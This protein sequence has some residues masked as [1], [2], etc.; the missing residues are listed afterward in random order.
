MTRAEIRVTQLFE[1]GTIQGMQAASRSWSKQP[2][3]AGRGKET[4]SSLES[5]ERTTALPTA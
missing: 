5:P 3:E 1:E 2:L 4:D